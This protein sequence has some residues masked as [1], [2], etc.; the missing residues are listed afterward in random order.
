[1]ARTLLVMGEVRIYNEK[2]YG[3]GE[4]N[5]LRNEKRI[6]IKALKR[7][8]GV[9]KDAIILLQTNTRTLN[10]KMKSHGINRKDYKL[11]QIR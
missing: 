8:N 2:D 6:I 11:K 10:N 4:F 3:T 7:C 1:M 9:R 5:L